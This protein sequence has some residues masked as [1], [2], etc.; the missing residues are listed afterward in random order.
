V[1]VRSCLGGYLL[2]A[3]FRKARRLKFVPKTPVGWT[4]NL[5]GKL[6]LVFIACI[7]SCWKYELDGKW[8]DETDPMV[9]SRLQAV[10]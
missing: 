3:D 9:A 8:R 10:K 6:F 5:T 4:S 2:P 1:A 7:E